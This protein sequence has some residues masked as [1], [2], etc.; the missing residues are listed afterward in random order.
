MFRVSSS[1][2]FVSVEYFGGVEYIGV[3]SEFA[4]WRMKNA[5]NLRIYSNLMRQRVF[6]SS[7][8]S[9]HQIATLCQAKGVRI[10][11]SVNEA[12][13]RRALTLDFATYH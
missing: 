8:T 1:L 13:A 6:E 3:F 11:S 7:A 12:D 2:W 9:G 5:H 4:M 10:V